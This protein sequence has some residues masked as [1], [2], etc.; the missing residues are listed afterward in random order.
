M[1]TEPSLSRAVVTIIFG[2]MAGG[3]TNTLAIWML[4]HPYERRGIGFFKLHG[5]I[6][7]NK[8]RLAKTI[9]RTVGQLS[10]PG[11][12]EAFDDAVSGFVTSLLEDDWGALRDELPQGFLSELEGAIGGIAETVA[13][14]VVEHTTTEEFRDKAAEFVNQTAR[15]GPAGGRCRSLNA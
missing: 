2:A 6:P 15:R 14:R 11:V 5:A 1:I 8:P 7:K 4:F 9:G 13:D 3:L 10:A 12:K